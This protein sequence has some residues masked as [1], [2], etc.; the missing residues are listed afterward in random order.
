MQTTMQ[1]AEIVIAV[2]C[3]YFGVTSHVLVSMRKH[4]ADACRC[5]KVC[6]F[7][8]HKFTDLTAA[9]TVKRMGRINHTSAMYQRTD[10]VRLIR[11]DIDFSLQVRTLTKRLEGLIEN[12]IWGAPGEEIEIRPRPA[13]YTG[14]RLTDSGFIET[15]CG[16][17]SYCI[18]DWI[19]KNKSTG[20]T[21]ICVDPVFTKKYERVL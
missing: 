21:I 13:E 3:R 11:L 6:Y 19:V 8:L 5:R 18:G 7:L 2:T 1:K 15:S 16:R 9:D 12:S 17:V 4:S 10:A 14:L 20:E